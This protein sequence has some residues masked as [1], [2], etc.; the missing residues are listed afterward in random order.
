[1]N[2]E[3]NLC[4]QILELTKRHGDTLAV[5][6]LSLEVNKKGTLPFFI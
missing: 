2:P 5:D 3:E 1:M 4:V 6:R